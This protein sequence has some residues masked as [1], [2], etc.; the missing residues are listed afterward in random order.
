MPSRPRRSDRR[1]TNPLDASVDVD[2]AILAALAQVPA[3]RR[4]HWLRGLLLAG[5]QKLTGDGHPDYTNIV[6]PLPTP[7]P[8]SERTR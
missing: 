4:P 1:I 7:K 3:N 6:F 8:T 2:A 5:A